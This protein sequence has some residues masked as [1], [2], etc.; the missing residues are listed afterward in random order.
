LAGLLEVD[1]VEAPELPLSWNVA[2]TQPVHAVA[3]SSGGVR[4]LGALLWVSS[5]VGPRT[6]GSRQADQRPLGDAE[7]P[8]FRS[9]ISTR[10]AL[11]PVTGFYKWRQAQPGPH[12]LRANRPRRVRPAGANSLFLVFPL[13][14]QLAASSLARNP[15]RTFQRSAPW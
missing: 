14:E 15:S 8:A 13:H 11:V 1:E 3:T 2:P 4:K 12:R 6:R 10:R 9:F 5:L 7:R